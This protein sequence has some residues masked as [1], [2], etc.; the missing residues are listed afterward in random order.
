[1]QGSCISGNFSDFWNYTKVYNTLNIYIESWVIGMHTYIKVFPPS[2]IC[3][4]R[5][6]QKQCSN[7]T[8]LCYVGC[9]VHYMIVYHLWP[10]PTKSLRQTQKLYKISKCPLKMS[11]SVLRTTGLYELSVPTINCIVTDSCTGLSSRQATVD[12]WSQAT[13]SPK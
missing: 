10:L 7:H 8:I 5:D 6:I 2:Q 11:T 12:L 4:I 1:M 9:P 3:P 13:A